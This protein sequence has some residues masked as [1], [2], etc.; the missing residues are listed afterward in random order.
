MGRD[1]LG[2]LNLSRA[3]HFYEMLTGWLQ[4]F[5]FLA[6]GDSPSGV[7]IEVVWTEHD[8]GSHPSIAVTWEEHVPRPDRYIALSQRSFDCFSRS[9]DASGLSLGYEELV[10]EESD[11][12]TGEFKVGLVK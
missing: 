7:D 11:E 3:D 8:L 12:A 4:E 9:V 5:I 2:G 6:V 10:H 1:V